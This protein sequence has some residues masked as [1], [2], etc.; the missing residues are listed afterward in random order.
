VP[1]RRFF[2]GGFGGFGGFGGGGDAEPETP[3]GRT[4]TVDLQVTL[5]DLYLG[6]S[7]TVRWQTRVCVCARARRAR[8]WRAAWHTRHALAPHGAEAVSVSVCA[9][10]NHTHTRIFLRSSLT[11]LSS[12]P[13]HR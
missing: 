3:K 7:F 4:V 8:A 13:F 6:N 1:R 5:R 2:G 12:H 9:H 11:L 10:A